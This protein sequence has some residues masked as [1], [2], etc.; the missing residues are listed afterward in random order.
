MSSERRRPSI[1]WLLAGLAR[2]LTSIVWKYEIEGE[3]PQEGPFIL[4]PNH[5][6]EADPVAVGVAVWRLGR[7]PRFMAKDSLFRIPV[8]GALL[9][10]SGQIP[11]SRDPR[12]GNRQAMDAAS[13]LIRTGRGVIIYPEGTL[14]RDPEGW[15]MR[16]KTGAVRLALAGRI[17]IYPCAHTGAERTLPPYGRFRLTWRS[18]LRIR[19]GEPLDL[20]AYEGRDPSQRELQEASDLLMRRITELLVP[21]REGTP[22]PAL[23]GEAGRDPE[24]A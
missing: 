13:L 15:P 6:S 11:V 20:S 19:V 4:A 1:F 5:T 21:L 18:P 24:P 8:V 3:L 17:P 23:P 12:K 16:G 22:P 9:R 7:L 10:M 14:T 2:P